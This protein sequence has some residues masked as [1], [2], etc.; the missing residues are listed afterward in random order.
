[1][2]TPRSRL[3]TVQEIVDVRW[4]SALNTHEY[5]TKW[6]GYAKKSWNLSKDFGPN[7]DDILLLTD[8]LS[9]STPDQE[10]TEAAKLL[11]L[12]SGRA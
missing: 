7:F 12:L 10:L 5:L 4:N 3:Y 11:Q 1:M 8:F 9:V 6:R 2:K